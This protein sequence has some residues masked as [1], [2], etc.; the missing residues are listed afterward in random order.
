MAGDKQIF[1]ILHLVSHLS[2][3]GAERQMSYLIP[4]LI[5]RGHEIHIAYISEGCGENHLK[6]NGV[7]LHTLQAVSNYD[8]RILWQI[9]KIIRHIK[10]DIVHSWI[11]Q[12]DVLGSIAAKMAEIPWVFREPSCQK[13]YP[14]NWK[15][16][17]RA[18]LAARAAMIISNSAGGDDYWHNKCSGVRRCVI[19]NALP[20]S[21]LKKSKKDPLAKMDFQPDHKSAVYVGRLTSGRSG[22][23]NLKLLVTAFA[24]TMKKAKVV[25]LLCGDGPQRRELEQFARRQGIA[26]KLHFMGHLPRTKVW[27]VL[28]SADV[29]VSLSA[30]EGCPNAVLEAMA[31]ECPLVVSDIPAHREILDEKSALFVDPSNTEQTTNAILAVLSDPDAAKH[32][33]KEARDKVTDYSVAAIAKQYEDVYAA[34]LGD[35]NGEN[36]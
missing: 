1:R 3:G 35:I 29:F 13:A 10:A 32:K 18:K 6:L 27:E 30:Y 21:D 20:L 36:E 23:K 4:E 24:E 28:K 26:D 19:P 16:W 15:H 33:A 14:P 11:I 7:R 17:L 34:V 5:R 31:C 22:E 9:L 12:M 25:G 2:G 8:P